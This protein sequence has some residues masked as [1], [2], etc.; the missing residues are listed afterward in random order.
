MWEPMAMLIIFGLTVATVLTVRRQG[1]SRN[2]RS[3]SDSWVDLPWMADT[4]FR[5][6]L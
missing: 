4:E 5:Q 2:R 1:L 3:W 6:A